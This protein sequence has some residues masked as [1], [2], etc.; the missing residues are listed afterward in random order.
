[1]PSIKVD[2]ALENFWDGSV[3]KRKI[4]IAQ[5][6]DDS[7]LVQSDTEY[8]LN[9]RLRR[10]HYS[11]TLEAHCPMFQ[12][13]KDESWFLILGEIRNKELLALK[14]VSSVNNQHRYHQLQFTTPRHLGK[15]HSHNSHIFLVRF[16][17]KIWKFISGPTEL[18]FYLISDCYIGL[19]QQYSICLNVAND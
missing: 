11:R 16:L 1:M 17:L 9:I 12:K 10:I 2:L 14:R 7:I 15:S 3:Q 18:T 19:D 4:T 8:T 13:G 5:N 6:N